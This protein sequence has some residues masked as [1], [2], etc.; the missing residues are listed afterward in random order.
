MDK[1]RYMCAAFAVVLVATF[2]ALRRSGMGHLEFLLCVVLLILTISSLTMFSPRETFDSAAEI[3]RQ[4][5]V[6][7]LDRLVSDISDQKD[8]P[9]QVKEVDLD[10]TRFEGLS[11]SAANELL[12]KYKRIN[13]FLCSLRSI[14]GEKYQTMMSSLGAPPPQVEE[15]GGED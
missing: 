15:E 5:I 6:P 1:S 13:F 4:T 3:M 7:S 8:P 10:A 12:V 14:H 2:M 9:K 11:E